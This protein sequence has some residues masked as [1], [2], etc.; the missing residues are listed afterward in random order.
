MIFIDYNVNAKMLELGNSGSIIYLFHFF[1]G[2]VKPID[3]N[4]IFWCLYADIL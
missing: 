4:V 1:I 2:F 3:Y